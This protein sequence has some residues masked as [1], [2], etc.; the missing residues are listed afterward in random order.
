MS[1]VIHD[2]V[3]LSEEFRGQAKSIGSR[4]TSIKPILDV[5]LGLVILVMSAPIILLAMVLVRLTSRS[6]A[7]YS[8]K[9]L[10]QG[11]RTITIYKIRTMYQD[12][13]RDTGA[14]WS[15]P[16]DRRITPVGRFLRW[17]HLDELPQ[18]VGGRLC[19]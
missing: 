9:R 17:A 10:G 6:P 5:S 15:P 12:S 16:G 18:L 1:A 8:Q 3:E 19:R 4:Y 7:I 13:E 14:V 11:G 2:V